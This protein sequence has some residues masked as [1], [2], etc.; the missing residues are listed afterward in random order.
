[1][2][3]AETTQIT[4]ARWL[5]EGVGA[6]EATEVN[7]HRILAPTDDDGDKNDW[8]ANILGFLL[9][10]RFGSAEAAYR[11]YRQ[12]E[13]ISVEGVCELLGISEILGEAILRKKKSGATMETIAQLLEQEAL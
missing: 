2:E 9:I 11:A 6:G 3:T 7:D 1:M 8:V 10:G 5:R 13:R 4:L 12:G